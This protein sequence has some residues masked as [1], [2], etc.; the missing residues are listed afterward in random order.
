VLKRLSRLRGV[1]R[2]AT[3]WVAKEAHGEAVRLAS[4]NLTAGE[5]RALDHPYATRHGGVLVPGDPAATSVRSGT[6]R[7]SWR[8][9]PTK[10]GTRLINDSDVAGF[11]A[12][13]HRPRSKM[14]RRPIPDRIKERTG[15]LLREF[16]VAGLR[17]I[18][19][20]LRRG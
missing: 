2:K 14:V 7:A 13:E 17:R 20:G 3:E 12:G 4:G 9:E 10:D 18:T 15:Y 8:T 5:L 11:L 16:V 1:A 19:A 6:F